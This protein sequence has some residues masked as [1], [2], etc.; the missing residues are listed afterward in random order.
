M[1]AIGGAAGSTF[2]ETIASG[3]QARSYPP[4]GGYHRD[5]A[6]QP[7]TTAEELAEDLCRA[8]PPT[9]NDVTILRD[10]RRID[11]RE[12]A[13]AGLTGLAAAGI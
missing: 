7:V 12:S 3:A 8:S 6:A 10:G 2:P 13:L 5:M 9:P 11:S 4:G 1:T